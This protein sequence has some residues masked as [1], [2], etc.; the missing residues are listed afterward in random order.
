MSAGQLR[1]A[2][3]FRLMTSR[4][5]SYCVPDTDMKVIYCTCGESIPSDLLLGEYRDCA[6][7][8]RDNLS[9]GTCSP[10]VITLVRL[11]VVVD[12]HKSN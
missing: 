6:A 1:S 10:D 7:Q 11:G 4:Q 9:Q 8:Y 12:T 5:W 3:S 2:F